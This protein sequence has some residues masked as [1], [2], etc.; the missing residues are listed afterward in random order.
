MLATPAVKNRSPLPPFFAQAESA[1]VSVTDWLAEDQIE[2]WQVTFE[3]ARMCRGHLDAER[4]NVPDL[5]VW[6][7]ERVEALRELDGSVDDFAEQFVRTWNRVS[8]IP[9]GDWLTT[10]AARAK[11][12][13]YAILPR[14]DG[15][16]TPGYRRFVSFCAHLSIIAGTN[17]ICLP[18]RQV[19]EALSVRKDTVSTYRQLGVTHGYLILKK[20]HRHV[21]GGRGEA[22]VYQFRSDLWP[23][24]QEKLTMR[25]PAAT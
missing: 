25:N 18:C 12:Q 9:A 23:D 1:A 10:A 24:L 13:V 4:V 11:V 15:K 8:T 5:A 6:L 16:V 22:T 21:P 20:V 3:I 17:I 2:D 19:G 7:Y 14:H